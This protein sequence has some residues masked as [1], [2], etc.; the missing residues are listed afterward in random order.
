MR[1]P[2]LLLW[3]LVF[4]TL[5]ARADDPTRLLR[6][7]RY[8]V[9][10]EHDL[11]RV[12][13][14]QYQAQTYRLEMDYTPFIKDM[15]MEPGLKRL[16]GELK[17]AFALA[18]GAARGAAAWSGDAAP[19]LPPRVLPAAL[20]LAGGPTGC[21]K[22][23]PGQSADRRPRVDKQLMACLG[24]I[25]AYHRQADLHLSRNKPEPAKDA[26]AQIVSLKCIARPNPEIREAVLDAYGRLARLNPTPNID[27]LAAEGIRLDNVFCTNSICVPSRATIMTGQYS[28]TNGITTLNGSLEPERQHLARLMKEAGY[29]NGFEVSMIAPNNRYVN[30]EKIAEAVVGMLAKINI[31]VNLKTMPKAQYWDEFD[32]QVADIQMLVD[33]T[34]GIIENEPIDIYV[35]PTFLPRA[36]AD[37]YDTL[38][39]EA[40]MKKVI[41]AAVKGVRLARNYT[42]DVEFSPEDASRNELSYLAE[43]V[44]AA[45]EA[46]I[47]PPMTQPKKRPPALF[48]RPSRASSASSLMTCSAS[49]RIS[50]VSG[51]TTSDVGRL[52]SMSLRKLRDEP[53]TVFVL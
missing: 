50:P 1:R 17:P 44:S 4:T 11:D 24:A 2:R 3:L 45:I 6:A 41:D 30:D 39:T 32:A 51:S 33:K 31:K 16:L 28:H 49:T 35:N 13:L 27:R 8:S 19:A 52:P 29:E 7:L 34:V 47:P 12:T 9:R 46:G 14:A 23:H 43:V 21:S 5:P 53:L 20:A 22:R 18:V 37:D 48:S 38:W 36:I 15:I 26:V 42:D 10:L 40:R 25:R